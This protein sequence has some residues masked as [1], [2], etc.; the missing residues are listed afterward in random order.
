[1]LSLLLV[2]TFRKYSYIIKIR[3][4]SDYSK[5]NKQVFNMLVKNINCQQLH[6]EILYFAVLIY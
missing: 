2:S 5:Y 6:L 1:M 4:G 3:W